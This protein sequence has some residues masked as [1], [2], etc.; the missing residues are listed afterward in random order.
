VQIVT[1]IMKSEVSATQ[2]TRPIV[3]VALSVLGLS[4][5][6]FLSGCADAPT[7]VARASC[8]DKGVFTGLLAE[9]S[10]QK[11]PKA[12]YLGNG[13]NFVVYRAFGR[14]TEEEAIATA[15]G[16]KAELDKA[17]DSIHKC[18]PVAIEDHQTVFDPTQYYCHQGPVTADTSN[19][20]RQDMLNNLR[21]IAS[22]VQDIKNH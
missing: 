2:S 19:Q 6:S 20:D 5:G 11:S 17:G 12:M 13:G 15:S 14:S 4:I 3:R 1:N 10:L 18:F 8:M 16:C 21:G 7:P 9:Y 22:A